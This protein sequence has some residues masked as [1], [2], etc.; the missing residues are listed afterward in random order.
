MRGAAR[1]HTVKNLRRTLLAVLALCGVLAVVTPSAGALSVPGADGGSEQDLEGFLTSVLRDVDG[2]W[3]RVMDEN[4][5]AEPTVRYVWIPARSR[6]GRRVH[7]PA[8]RPDRG[9]LLPG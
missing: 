1:S 2:Y 7:R 3:T 5:Y 9:L 4:G 8:D 6:R